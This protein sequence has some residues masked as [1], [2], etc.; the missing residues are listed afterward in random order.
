MQQ[1]HELRGVKKPLK[2][3]LLVSAG[4]CL[5]PEMNSLC[6]L[7]MKET[8]DLSWDQL[9]RQRRFLKRAGFSMPSEA[10]IRAA[11]K[12]V[13][14]APIDTRVE[15]FVDGKG[16]PKTAVLGKTS[17]VKDFVFELLSR[18]KEMGTLTW[19]EVIPEDEI[20]IKFGGDHGGGK[21][22]VHDA[23]CQHR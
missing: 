1:A 5:K 6:A 14:V 11:Q 9:K 2:K 10:Q 7:A 18:H 4:L 23:S 19:N 22:Q 20:W 13:S 21:P 8:I 16:H 15:S 17:S 12:S 3:K